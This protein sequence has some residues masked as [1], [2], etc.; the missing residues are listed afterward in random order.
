MR[1]VAVLAVV[2]L[3]AGCSSSGSKS[4]GNTAADGIGQTKPAAKAQGPESTAALGSTITKGA[5]RITMAGP[6]TAVK[7]G[8]TGLQVT[9]NVTMTNTAS[10][11]DVDGP[12]NFMVRCD[13]NRDAKNDTFGNYW[14]T[15]TAAGKTIPAGKTVT[16][17]AVVSWLKWNSTVR[18]TGPTTIEAQWPLVGYLA[19]TLPADVVAKVNTAG[20]V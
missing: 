16:G 6:V 1:R 3:T 10:S 13:A 5:L 15:T 20:G 18:C 14:A 4:T 19:W 11:G 2:M 12:E 8:D 17:I 9:F 7:A